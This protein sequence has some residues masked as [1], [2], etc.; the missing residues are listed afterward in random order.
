[1]DSDKYLKAVVEA[2]LYA[3]P[4]SVELSRLEQV[5]QTDKKTLLDVLDEL[6]KD[7]S[8]NSRGICVIRKGDNFQFITKKELGEKVSSYLS[9]RK[10]G[11]SN[12]AMETLAIAAYNQPVTKTYI[13]RI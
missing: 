6:K 7:C 3:S 11:L 10:T 13:S 8:D 1:M 5:L 4:T 2:I 9:S 12:A